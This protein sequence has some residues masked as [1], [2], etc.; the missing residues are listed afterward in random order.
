MRELCEGENAQLLQHIWLLMA[1]QSLK[2]KI[3]CQ[4]LGE[5]KAAKGE[6]WFSRK[7]EEKK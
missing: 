3:C 1:S 4:K 7:G 5:E 2:G 6:E